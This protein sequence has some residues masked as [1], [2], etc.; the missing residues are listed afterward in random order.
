MNGILH[1]LTHVLT[2]Y[3]PV[4]FFAVVLTKQ[5]GLPMAAI[6]FLIVAGGLMGTGHMPLGLAVG[7]TVV[8]AWWGGQFG[9]QL[10]RRH[11]QYMLEN[12]LGIILCVGSG[13]GIGYL[14]RERSGLADLALSASV[15]AGPGAALILLGSVAAY[16]LYKI[17]QGSREGQLA[18]RLSTVPSERARRMGTSRHV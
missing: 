13:I 2:Q 8:V 15:Q 6:P 5:I 4:T 18:P 9:Y 3:V 14:F 7:F 11:S 16:A 10:G 1:F 17:S 12:G